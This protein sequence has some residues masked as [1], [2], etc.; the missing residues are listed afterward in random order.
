[1]IKNA[2]DI[3]VGVSWILF[4]FFKISYKLKKD[5]KADLKNILLNAF[6]LS[7]SQIYKLFNKID[8]NKDGLIT[9]DEF[10]LYALEKPEYARIF[11]TYHELKAKQSHNKNDDDQL[12]VS[13]DLDRYEESQ[14][15][16][17]QEAPK[18]DNVE[19]KKND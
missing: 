10:K 14:K 16:A 19:D 12:F 1:L 17:K 9:Y 7:H 11:L 8:K 5:F 18:A 4:L 15:K 13:C 2:K 6:S 3:L